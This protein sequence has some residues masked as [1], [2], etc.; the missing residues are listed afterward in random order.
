MGTFK[1]RARSFR[2]N[3][4]TVCYI[5]VYNRE[6]IF[7]DLVKTSTFWQKTTTNRCSSHFTC[8]VFCQQLQESRE[9]KTVLSISYDL[10]EVNFYYSLH[11]PTHTHTHTHTYTHAYIHTHTHTHTH[12]HTHTGLHNYVVNHFARVVESLYWLSLTL[13]GD[14][15][16]VC[17]QY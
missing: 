1:I 6:D 15:I 11:T 5:K 12:A 16:T 3:V 4:F 8:S 9:L 17:S 14:F 2:S 13:P 7:N 10:N